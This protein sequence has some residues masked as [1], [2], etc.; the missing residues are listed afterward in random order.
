M[1]THSKVLRWIELIVIFIGGPLIFYFNILRIPKFIP[2]LLVFAVSIVY[3]LLSKSFNRKAFGINGF[4]NWKDFGIRIGITLLVITLLSLTL[5]PKEHLFELPINHPWIW[6]MI[7]IFYPL[8]SA[9]TQEVIYRGFYFH[10]YSPLFKSE[11]IAILV[12]AFLFGFL[13][14]I[15]RNWV[16]VA[17]TI[18]IGLVWAYTYTKHGSLLI[19]SAEHAIV[20][21]YIFTIGLGYFF[22]LP[23][24]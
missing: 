16:A 7:M 19:V 18:V 11:K 6:V 20:G 21:N 5:L 15:F 8:W 2:L 17:A 4:D 10:R 24:F 14:I 23:D 9:F 3:L 12:N 22:Y 13:H 1:T